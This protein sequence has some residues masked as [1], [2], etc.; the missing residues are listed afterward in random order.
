MIKMKILILM[1]ASQ[2]AIDKTYAT[3]F[4]NTIQEVL[5]KQSIHLNLKISKRST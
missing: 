5:Y 1:R 4:L 3:I 2:A